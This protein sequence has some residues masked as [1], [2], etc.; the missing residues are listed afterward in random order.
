MSQQQN[1][2]FASPDKQA[3]DGPTD[4]LD[5]Y[6][7]ASDTADDELL[8]SANLGFGNY[9]EGMMWQQVESF[10]D[11]LFA[12]AAFARLLVGRCIEQTQRRLGE[13]AWEDE[14]VE[15]GADESKHDRREY[16]DRRGDE[17][18]EELSEQQRR[19]AM[20]KYYGVGYEWRPPHW[21]MMMARHESSRG[22]N[23]HLLDNLFGRI[24]KKIVD[25]NNSRGGQLPRLG[26][27]R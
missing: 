21:R 3:R 8:E 12:D 6:G 24:K 23:A 22:R 27:D 18:W 2:Q 16:I 17:I 13:E 25:D 11:A 14:V 26:G 7:E 20:E 9:S 10:K 5:I 19:D 15:S 1:G 4:S